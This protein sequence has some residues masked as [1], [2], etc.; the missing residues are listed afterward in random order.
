MLI[1][2]LQQLLCMT[3][4]SKIVIISQEEVGGTDHGQVLE[5]NSRERL[6]QVFLTPPF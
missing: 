4:E 1:K 5:T 6:L 2:S 3:L